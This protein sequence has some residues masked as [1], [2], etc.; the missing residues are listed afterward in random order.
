[1]WKSIRL[2]TRIYIILAVLVMVTMAGGGIM[3]W[4][5][6]QMN[7]YMALIIERELA[8]YK[9]AEA[10]ETALINQKGFVSYYFMD[11]DPVWLR[12]LGEYRQIFKTRMQEARRHTKAREQ[13]QAL[14]LIENEYL[15]YIT[16]KD[17]VIHHYELG[18]REAGAEL[19]PQ[20]RRH[21]FKILDLCENYKKIHLD[22]IRQTEVRSRDQAQKL[23]IIAITGIA[24]EFLL[25]L[26]LL[27]VLIKNILAPIR[28][29][30][31]EVDTE[32]EITASDEVAALSQGVRGLIEDVDHTQLELER[33]RQHLLQTEKLALVGKLAAGMAHSIR[34]PFTSVK[35][36]LFS[37]E[38]SLELSDIQ[39][40]D[41]QV[42]SEEIRHIDTVIQ[43]FLEF[44]RRPKLEMQKIS[45][46]TIVD[47]TLQLLSHRLKS[48]NVTIEIMRTN[49]LPEIL[50]DAEQIKEVLVNLVMN[51][52]EAMG[53][54]GR[55]TISEDESFY[56]P[57][58]RVAVI[59]ISDTGPGIPAP[60]REKVFQPFYSTKEEGTGLGLAIANR[61]IEEHGG[62]I[63]IESSQD[64]GATF[65]IMLPIPE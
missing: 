30:T 2:R 33:S 60:T 38:R 25:G 63:E 42:I 40:D 54:G 26:L 15:A 28:S 47:R 13:K 58:K 18:E 17:Q 24:A 5:T 35:M 4:Y 12:Q 52:C 45:P 22:R 46:S 51:A 39:K 64:M 65:V 32:G 49:P 20:V 43:N 55:I 6:Y 59:R 21:F 29:L 36:R 62:Q 23:R 57:L 50:A 48:Y 1:M 9:V 8:S 11:G 44:S 16:T 14:D 27:V 53:K 37:L 10:L 19:H 3:V 56:R 41:L 7:R 34:N 31:R 61:I